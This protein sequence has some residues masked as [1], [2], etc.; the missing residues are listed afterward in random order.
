M[1]GQPHNNQQ[2][3]HCDEEGRAAKVRVGCGYAIREFFTVHFRKSIA[4]VK[5]DCSAGISLGVMLIRD[6][7]ISARSSSICA[8][9]PEESRFGVR[10]A[11][12]LLAV[13]VILIY[14]V[15]M[16][17]YPLSVAGAILGVAAL[18][19]M[20]FCTV[21]ARLSRMIWLGIITLALVAGCAIWHALCRFT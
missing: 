14:T 10:S 5:G 4:A 20:G 9:T 2:S 18:I 19:F 13:L 17:S 7:L 1:D 8:R 3:Q 6:A 21:G 16:R 11:T 12:V 15:A